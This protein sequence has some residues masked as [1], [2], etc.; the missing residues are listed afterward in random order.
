MPIQENASV[1]EIKKTTLEFAWIDITLDALGMVVIHQ[2]WGVTGNMKHIL[3]KNFFWEASAEGE[4]GII[5]DK[6]A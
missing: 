4:G 5:V 6:G 1:R 2:F 3:R